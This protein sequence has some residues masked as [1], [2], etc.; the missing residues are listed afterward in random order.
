[1]KRMI[2]AAVVFALTAT[3][4]AQ[5]VDKLP[6]TKEKPITISVFTINQ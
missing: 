2:M 1:M 3:L 4:M 6:V 5:T